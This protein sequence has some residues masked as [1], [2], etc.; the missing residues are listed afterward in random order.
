MT[1]EQYMDMLVDCIG[2]LNPDIV[3][4]RLT[5]DGPKEILAAPDWRRNKRDVLNTFHHEMKIRNV[6]QGK[7]L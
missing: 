7:F 2:H 6:Y 5:G 3:I 4:H 1:K